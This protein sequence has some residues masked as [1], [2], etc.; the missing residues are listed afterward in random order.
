MDYDFLEL[1]QFLDEKFQNIDKKFAQIDE[2]FEYIEERF[3]RI[4]LHLMWIYE[5]LE[6]L[7]EKKADKED[8]RKL[9]H[10]LDRYAKRADDY[11]VGCENV[12]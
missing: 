12:G 5:K 1:I 8:V 10:G 4:D 2:R 7:D 6:E 3:R 9:L 11:F